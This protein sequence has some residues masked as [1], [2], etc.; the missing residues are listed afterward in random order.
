MVAEEEANRRRWLEDVVARCR[1]C[2]GAASEYALQPEL[3]LVK[4]DAG[5][6]V[7]MLAEDLASGGA[8]GRGYRRPDRNF[9]IAPWQHRRIDTQSDRHF[10]TGDQAAW[11]RQSGDSGRTTDATH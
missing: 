6:E 9:R 8:R 10:C 5:E 7:P 4:G 3:H 1:R 2:V 11:F